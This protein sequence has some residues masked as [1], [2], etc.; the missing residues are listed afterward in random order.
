MYF[1][2]AAKWRGSMCVYKG[3]GGQA[4]HAAAVAKQLANRESN[5]FTKPL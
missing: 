2:D 3:G 5:Q 4:G 1:T